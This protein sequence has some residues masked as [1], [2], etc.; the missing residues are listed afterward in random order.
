MD[1]DDIDINRA[2][3]AS[4][5]GRGVVLF[6]SGDWIQHE[7]D[8]EHHDDLDELGLEDAPDGI[9]V[10]EGYPVTRGNNPETMYTEGEGTF[11]RPTA[12]EWGSIEGGESPW[13]KLGD[14]HG[15]WPEDEAWMYGDFECGPE[16]GGGACL[17]REAT[18]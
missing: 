10:W 15:P 17:D 9:S 2:V 8:E 14:W 5:N 16:V 6:Y 7:I 1:D 3:V 4:R 18:R 12:R 11:R 13:P